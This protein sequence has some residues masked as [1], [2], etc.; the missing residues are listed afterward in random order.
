MK[1]VFSLLLIASYSLLWVGCKSGDED[2][3]VPKVTPTNLTLES[4]VSTDGS[5]LVTFT[6]TADNADKFYFFP[7]ESAG[8]NPIVSTTGI[9]EYHYSAT[10]SYNPKVVATSV[11]NLSIDKTIHISVT[12]DLVVV[13]SDEFDGSSLNGDFWTHESGNNG[14]WGNAE[15]E[16]YQSANSTVADGF[17]TITAKL[18]SVGGQNYTSSR[19]ISKGKKEFK[20]GR[21]DIRAKLPKGQGIWPALWMLGANISTVNW[22]A[23][24]EIDIMELIGGGVGRDN[25]VYGTVHWSNA[26][27]AWTY[28]GGNKTLEAGDFADD[29]HIF[30]IV[31][32]SKSITWKVDDVQF[33]TKDTS[34]E[35]MSEFRNNFFLIFNIAVGGNWPGNPDGTTVFPQ[36]MVIDYVKLLQ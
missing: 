24:G 15:L 34:P 22:P 7:G 1:K 18:E 16:Y 10:G 12:K 25:K 32:T 21:V 4:L 29:F 20:F 5:G 31:W 33:Y 17:L 8:E 6:A 2:E 36:T 30:S 19:I 27:N 3:A 13:W 9:V 11:D 28:V 35:E 14:G 23:C 26:A